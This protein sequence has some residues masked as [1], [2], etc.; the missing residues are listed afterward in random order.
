MVRLIKALIVTAF[1]VLAGPLA[2]AADCADLTL[3]AT[4]V[5][6]MSD[7]AAGRICRGAHRR[8]SSTQRTSFCSFSPVTE[9]AVA[10]GEGRS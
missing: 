7:P 3:R 5:A 8:R 10:S 2:K 4:R 1:G 9:K 6:A